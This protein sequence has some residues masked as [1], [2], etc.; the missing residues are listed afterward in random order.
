MTSSHATP[1]LFKQH[2]LRRRI[3][4]AHRG[5]QQQQQ[6]R[7]RQRRREAH[8]LIEQR[9]Y[10]QMSESIRQLGSLV[11]TSRLSHMTELSKKSAGIYHRPFNNG[12]CCVT[13]YNQLRLTEQ[14]R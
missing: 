3:A 7:R 12:T 6:R 8:N 4:E 11:P 10:H 13:H 2:D 9:R 14:A 1:D 5:Q